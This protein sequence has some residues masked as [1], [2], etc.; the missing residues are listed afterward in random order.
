MVFLYVG[1]DLCLAS[2][3]INIKNLHDLQNLFLGY[4]HTEAL[5][6]IFF[7]FLVFYCEMILFLTPVL[8]V[9]RFKLTRCL[10]HKWGTKQ[11]KCITIYD[12]KFILLRGESLVIQKLSFVWRWGTVLIG[13]PII[14]DSSNLG[15]SLTHSNKFSSSRTL[16]RAAYAHSVL[17]GY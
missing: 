5:N 8:L 15:L 12:M 2:L 4:E 10:H 1:R 16:S 13:N 11:N 7:N 9:H 17:K 3:I 6:I 14:Y